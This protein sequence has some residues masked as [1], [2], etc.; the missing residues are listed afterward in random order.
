MLWL[1]YRKNLKKYSS[2]SEVNE[3]SSERNS[4]IGRD[5]QIAYVHDVLKIWKIKL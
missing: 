1:C 5:L 4:T 3:K 2:S